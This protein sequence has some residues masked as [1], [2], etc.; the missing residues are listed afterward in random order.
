VNC[1]INSTDC[2]KA[3]ECLADPELDLGCGEGGFGCGC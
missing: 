2:K 3:R 1:V